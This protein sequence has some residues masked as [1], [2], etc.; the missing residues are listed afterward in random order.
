MDVIV[1]TTLKELRKSEITL[2]ELAKTWALEALAS[3]Q[4]ANRHYL[5]Y[6][7]KEADL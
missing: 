7:R 3:Y 4:T 2:K 5:L 1:V 6:R